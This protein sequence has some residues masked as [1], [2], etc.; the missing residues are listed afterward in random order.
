MEGIFFELFVLSLHMENLSVYERLLDLLSVQVT[1]VSVEEKVLYI[2]CETTCKTSKCPICGKDTHR[3]NQYTTREI[4]DLNMG[5]RE[6]YLRVNMKQFYCK[7]CPRYFHESLDFAELNEGYTHR[8]KDFMFLVSQQQSYQQTGRL[9]NINSKTVERVVL[10]KCEATVAVS[11]RYAQVKRLGIDEQSHKKGKQDYICILTDLDRGTIVDILPDRKK[12]T[13]EAHF[14]KLGKAFC[15]QITDVSCDYWRGYISASQN[16]FPNASITLDR[17]HI[18]KLLNA[19]LDKYRKELRKD[20]KD[21]DHFKHIKWSLFKQYQNLSDKE[22]DNLELAFEDAP[23]LKKMYFTREKFHHI[24][25]N[26]TQISQA[27]LDVEKWIQEVKDN[28]ISKFDDF[29][30]TLNNTKNYVTNYVKNRISNAVTEGANNLIRAVRRF[31][32]GM[33]NFEHLRLRALAF[34]Y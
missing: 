27:L 4:R 23:E 30:K 24:L 18:T 7:D 33:P 12:E 34:S 19:P 14:K 8:Q 11:A 13:L 31:S 2:F 9:L 3:I 22:I 16:C 32:F 1:G 29:V 25:D 21:N 17:F 5:I 15:E 10:S 20:H 6:V 28:N 26:N